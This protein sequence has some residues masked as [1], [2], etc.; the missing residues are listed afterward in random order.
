MKQTNPVAK[1]VFSPKNT[2]NDGD[3]EKIAELGLAIK[4]AMSD[5]SDGQIRELRRLNDL[6]YA[7]RGTYY[8]PGDF[9]RDDL[10]EEAAL[11]AVKHYGCALAWIYKQTPQLCEAAV[12]QDGM[13]IRYA[14]YKTP[15]ICAAAV[16]KNGHALSLIDNP[17]P[18]T[19]LALVKRWGKL[20]PGYVNK[21]ES[22][23]DPQP[24]AYTGIENHTP[25]SWLRAGAKT[26]RASRYA[27]MSGKAL[28][29]MYSR[30]CE[31]YG[32]VLGDNLYTIDGRF[33][34]ELIPEDHKS[35]FME[36]ISEYVFY[37]Q[38]RE[39]SLIKYLAMEKTE[40]FAYHGQERAT[41]SMCRNFFDIPGYKCV[42]YHDWMKFYGILNEC[43]KRNGCKSEKEYVEFLKNFKLKFL[44]KS[45][46]NKTV[47]KLAGLITPRVYS[48]SNA[49][50]GE[51]FIFG[52]GEKQDRGGNV[53]VLLIKKEYIRSP[54][55]I[56]DFV[57]RTDGED[58]LL[59]RQESCDVIFNNKWRGFF[60]TV[61]VGRRIVPG[62]VATTIEEGFKRI[63]LFHY[64]AS[65]IKDIPQIHPI[66]NEDMVD[67]MYYH[68]WGHLI[69]NRHM[70]LYHKSVTA[71][72]R[73]NEGSGPVY[74]VE[75][76]MADWAPDAPEGGKGAMGR[77]AEFAQIDENRAAR[78]LY[79]YCSDNWFVDLS[80]KGYLVHA[81]LVLVGLALGFIT[82]N[83]RV[84]TERLI[85]EKDEVWN[86][87]IKW[88]RYFINACLDILYTAVFKISE[89][90][91]T[92][93]ELE[94]TLLD[95]FHGEKIAENAED[96]KGK[97][98][99]WHTALNCLK[100]FSPESWRQCQQV[101]EI[102]KFR[103]E[104]MVLDRVSEGHGKKYKDS[105]HQFIIAKCEKIGV[106]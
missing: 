49:F 70:G 71:W 96:M 67:G 64:G 83:G 9:L 75:E 85:K 32:P 26:G 2:G 35:D 44:G 11:D 95:V 92:Y 100:F 46:D 74:A 105:L 6:Y 101:Q 15:E 14:D 60:E 80:D 63:A 72:F 17:T 28:M 39:I 10:T 59:I 5:R 106:L 7:A 30:Y 50:Y 66:F 24:P 27:G 34:D 12:K 55:H 16:Q 98:N 78:C 47:H 3:F 57:A 77:F 33:I 21:K 94:K 29:A 82:N 36:L 86:S 51:S 84:D 65:D 73:E 56:L 18:E 45:L 62:H 81:S 54:E 76:A 20:A 38:L 13:A 42:T 79:V 37:R 93:D 8:L 53:K 68:E 40:D 97:W 58:A 25:L 61:A 89:Y 4:K 19:Y 91:F 104:Q 102:E 41:F 22:A 52:L 99:Y 43:D 103:V 1:Y 31:K 23:S 48:S 69:A 90:T 87:L 88:H